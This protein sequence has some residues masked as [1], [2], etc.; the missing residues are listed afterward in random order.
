MDEQSRQMFQ[1]PAQYMFK[2]L[3]KV[4]KRDDYI[5]YTLEKM[6]R[7]LALRV[8]IVRVGLG[9]R[10]QVLDVL[11]QNLP[12]GAGALDLGDVQPVVATEL[13]C[14]W[15]GVHLRLLGPLGELLQVLD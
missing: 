13:L 2:D 1:M 10:L 8:I 6:T 12:V 5:A 3:P 14:A 11:E 7:D 15:G 9:S 4:G